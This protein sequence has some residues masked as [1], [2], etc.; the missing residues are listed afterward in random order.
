MYQTKYQTIKEVW[1]TGGV[2]SFTEIRSL[3]H[4]LDFILFHF[5]E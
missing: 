1:N 2:Y 3:K 4:L 5:Q